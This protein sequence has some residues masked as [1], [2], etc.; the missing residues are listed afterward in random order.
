MIYD[1]DRKSKWSERLN[2]ALR[3]GT[4]DDTIVVVND[5]IREL[6]ECAAKRFSFEGQIVTE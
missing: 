6:A 4:K 2:A 5:D 3:E 1:I